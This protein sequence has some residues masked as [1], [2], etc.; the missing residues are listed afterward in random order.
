[1]MVDA[2]DDPEVF[3]EMIEKNIRSHINRKIQVEQ[4]ERLKISFVD[5]LVAVLGPSA[6]TKETI[7][8]WSKAFNVIIATYNKVKSEL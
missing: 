4:Y 1:M 7:E 3:M 8:A 5:T 6:M 2:L